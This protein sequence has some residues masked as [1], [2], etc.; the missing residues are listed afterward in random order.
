MDDIV[1]SGYPQPM[2]TKCNQCI[3]NHNKKRLMNI[4]NLE[5]VPDDPLCAWIT[6]QSWE[7]C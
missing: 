2:I 3:T 7:S 5:G 6:G 4:I 1:I